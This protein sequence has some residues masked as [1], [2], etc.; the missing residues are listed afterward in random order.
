MSE[1]AEVGVGAGP[2]SNGTQTI[3]IDR[4]SRA[5]TLPVAH[6]RRGRTDA[7]SLGEFALNSTLDTGLVAAASTAENAASVRPS[8]K[9]PAPRPLCV[10]CGEVRKA[11]VLIALLMMVKVLALTWLP[12]RFL[13]Q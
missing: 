3:Y 1:V 4:S 2:I 9:R 11:A 13:A 8:G 6:S 7:I 10:T 5:T 12:S